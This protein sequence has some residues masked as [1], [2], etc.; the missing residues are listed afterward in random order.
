M[1]QSVNRTLTLAQVKSILD[2]CV[3]ALTS[4]D[5]NDSALDGVTE[6]LTLLVVQ[7]EN[8]M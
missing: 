6:T 8:Q 2:L 1:E 5:V 3:D 7:L 4:L